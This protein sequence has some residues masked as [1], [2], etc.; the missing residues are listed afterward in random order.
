M[1]DEC[2]QSGSEVVR[3][4]SIVGCRPN[5]STISNYV[6]GAAISRGPFQLHLVLVSLGLDTRLE[7]NGSPAAAS[8]LIDEGILLRTASDGDSPV[9]PCMD[10]LAGPAEAVII[11]SRIFRYDACVGLAGQRS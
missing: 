10:V 6:D 5:D 4:I 8:L 11:V 3:G 1:V 7:R 9:R 2:S